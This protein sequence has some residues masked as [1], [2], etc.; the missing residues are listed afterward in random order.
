MNEDT[1]PAL[2]RYKRTKIAGLSL[3][4]VLLSALIWFVFDDKERELFVPVVIGDLPAGL[5]LATLP[6]KEVEVRV[7]GQHYRIKNLHPGRY[8]YTI[9]PSTL[10]VGLHPIALQANRFGFPE[11]VSVDRIHPDII[12]LKIEPEIKKQVPITVTLSGKPAAGYHVADAV[13]RPS[14][15]ILK[16]PESI[17]QPLS[18]ALTQSIDIAGLSASIKKAI[19]LDLP[20][21]LAIDGK[22]TLFQAEVYLEE[23]IITKRYKEIIVEGIGTDRNHTI[24]PS[25]IQIEISGPMKVLERMDARTDINAYVDLKNL[26]PGVYVRP[27]AISLPLETILVSVNPKIFSITIK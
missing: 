16:G 13:S 24:A 25:S 3:A 17:L 19:G 15:V 22:D 1:Q 10:P 2:T 21:N 9:D 7:K 8:Q 20:D 4:V 26:K 14:S 23:K 12:L 18:Q 5:I 6:P 27:V 11:G